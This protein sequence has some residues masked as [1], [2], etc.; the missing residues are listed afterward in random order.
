MEFEPGEIQ[1]LSNAKILHSRAAYEDDPDSEKRR[2]LL[3]LRL[4]AY[5][6]ATVDD[7]LRG[8]PK[9]NHATPVA[10]IP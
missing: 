10:A 4:T 5:E 1:L 2:H 9:R 3:R 8:F 7:A 6:F